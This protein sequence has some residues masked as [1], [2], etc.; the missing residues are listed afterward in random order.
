MPPPETTQT[1][2]SAA[3]APLDAAKYI[4]I[5]R[6]MLFAEIKAG[7]IRA[8]KAGRRTLLLRS[9]LD[10][11]LTSLPVTSGATDTNTRRC[12]GAGC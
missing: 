7:R 1:I 3:F 8:R 2:S 11:W 10:A 4:G 12:A 6:T 9:D 5:G